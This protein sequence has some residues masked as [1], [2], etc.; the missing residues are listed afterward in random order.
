[1]KAARALLTALAIIASPGQAEDRPGDFDF[2]V[3]ALS[4]SPAWCATD[5]RG[6]ASPQCG[7]G[8]DRG[9]VLHGLWPQYEAGRPEFCYEGRA[10]WVADEI[11]AEMADIMPDRELVFSEW[12]KHGTCSGL[13]PASYFAT[14]RE[15]HDRIVVPPAFAGRGSRSISASDAEQ[16]FI[17][18]NPGMEADGIAISCA[19]GLLEE[20]RI[21]LT[22]ALGFR[23]CADVDRRGCRQKRL[24]LPAAN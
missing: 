16:S 5:G 4:W 6:S 13:S 7:A 10:P 20:V 17:S 19:D 2:Y 3:L 21:C 24:E 15:A 18:V 14:S 11:A 8:G 1:M 23:P 12:R 9:F 22:R